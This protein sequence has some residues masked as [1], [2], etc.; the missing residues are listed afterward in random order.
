MFLLTMTIDTEQLVNVLT[1]VS[2]SAYSFNDVQQP[3]SADSLKSS[4]PY[5]GL[6]LS[7]ISAVLVGAS[8]ILQ[9][10]GILHSTRRNHRK[11]CFI[12]SRYLLRELKWIDY[13]F[14]LAKR[15]LKKEIKIIMI[16]KNEAIFLLKTN[17]ISGQ[18]VSEFAYLKTWNWWMGMLCSKC[19]LDVSLIR[20]EWPSIF[21]KLKKVIL[22][23]FLLG[24][25]LMIPNPPSDFENLL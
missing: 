21:K 9:K 23:S 13:C 10:K 8:F 24:N 22:L 25:Y 6:L 18:S 15:K 5:F 12:L 16:L 20:G 1:D 14:H 4:H 19:F 3:A 7:V 17:L 2:P 11:Y